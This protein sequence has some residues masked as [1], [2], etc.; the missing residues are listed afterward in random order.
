MRAAL[1]SSVPLASLFCALAVA[2]FLLLPSQLGAALEEALRAKGIALGELAALGVGPA[3]EYDDGSLANEVFAGARRDQD[4]V[5]MAVLRTG[6]RVVGAV[7][8]VPT[9]VDLGADAMAI[10]HLHTHAT[11]RGSYLLVKAPIPVVLGDNGLLLALLSTERMREKQARYRV[12]AAVLAAGVGLLGLLASAAVGLNIA[13]VVSSRAHVVELLKENEIARAKAEAANA[14]KGIFV[15]SISHELRTPLNGVL[16]MNR[17][18]LE[19][20]LTRAQRELARSA[21]RSGEH[22]LSTINDLLDFSK[23]EAGKLEFEVTEF[24]VWEA[25]EDVAELTVIGKPRPEVE[26]LCEIDPE[27]PRWIRGD[28][29]RLRQ[30]LTNLVGNARKFTAHG[31]V[32]LRVSL[33]A[34][35]R[36]HFAIEDTGIGIDAAQHQSIFDA[37]TQADSATTRKFGGTGLGL[38]ICQRIVRQLGTELTVASTPGEGSTF[39]FDWPF[40]NAVRAP[41]LLCTIRGEVLCVEPHQRL[42]ENMTRVMARWGLACRAVPTLEAGMQQ[43]ASGYAPRWVI[44]PLE[45]LESSDVRRALSPAG[46]Q[47]KLVVTCAPG[48]VTPPWLDG[49]GIL[50]RPVRP[51]LLHRALLGQLDQRAAADEAAPLL[52]RRATE[53]APCLLVADDNPANRQV[54]EGMLDRL[55]LRCQVVGDGAAAVAAVRAGG[56]FAAALM[57][58]HMPVMDGYEATRAIR[59]LEVGSGRRLAVI[60]VTA[61]AGD[62]QREL[63]LRA[64]MDDFLTKPLMLGA[65]ARTLSAWVDFPPV[66]SLQ[67]DSGAHESHPAAQPTLLLVADDNDA[68]RRVLSGMLEQLGYRCEVVCDGAAAVEAC[69][70]GT[71]FAAILMDIQMPIMDG[72]DATREIRK[73]G[74]DDASWLPII[75]VT[76]H[77]DEGQHE[78]ALAAGMDDLLAKPVSMQGLREKLELWLAAD[79]A[80]GPANLAQGGTMRGTLNL[81]S[82][83]GSGVDVAQLEQLLDLQSDRRPRL[84]QEVI[85]SFLTELPDQRQALREAW[86]RED[87]AALRTLSHRLKGGSMT[88][89]A[90]TLHALCE[91]LERWS[92]H[93]PS[94]EAPDFGDVD[95]AIVDA[96]AV[97]RKVVAAA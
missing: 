52:R 49:H 69:R 24:D 12:H 41:S 56:H 73:L 8:R 10:G 84:A 7:G 13:R 54:V 38:A 5:Y 95:R 75:A 67:P 16:G 57:D 97:L 74:Y 66:E 88:V 85:A 6:G 70:A 76:A 83:R 2:T 86:E 91:R 29:L 28:A 4:V 21:Q 51:T 25:V 30:V 1:R 78:A 80:P 79:S 32:A 53:S 61:N 92:A 22:L 58:V 26:N 31:H 82:A 17:L 90:V 37:F 94:G 71:A 68:N 96:E 9:D 60:G 18:L 46:G 20:Q 65:L 50:P 45:S 27:V 40:E 89:G 19:S 33:V 44:V 3:L 14:A 35:G 42:S 39:S 63:V 62:E 81:D 77:S 87:H 64:G 36:L 48:Q 72:H 23:I 55:G 47:R 93:G 11:W 15:A 34:K 43:L 59:E